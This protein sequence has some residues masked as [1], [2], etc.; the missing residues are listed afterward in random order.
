MLASSKSEIQGSA[1][2]LELAI[3]NSIDIC[4]RMKDLA[5]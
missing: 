4:E 1:D 5:L 3:Q 2:K